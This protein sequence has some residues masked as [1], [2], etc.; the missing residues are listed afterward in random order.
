VV[1]ADARAISPL[2]RPAVVHRDLYRPNTLAAVGR[3]RCLL[4]FETARSGTPRPTS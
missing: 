2:V 3:F 4:D 1:L